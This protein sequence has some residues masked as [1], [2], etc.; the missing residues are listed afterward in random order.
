MKFIQ[1]TPELQ[2]YDIYTANEPRAPHCRAR[3]AR[4]VTR[5]AAGQVTAS[6][7][8]SGKRPVSLSHLLAEDAEGHGLLLAELGLGGLHLLLREVADGKI[9]DNGPLAARAGHGERIH[10]ALRASG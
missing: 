1:N 4:T 5:P 2:V 10:E 9:L 3:P 7:G 8:N 6:D